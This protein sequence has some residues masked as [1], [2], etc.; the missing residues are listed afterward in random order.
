MSTM[1]Q[2]AP[3]FDAD[4]DT[5]T[6][7]VHNHM[8]AYVHFG[9]QVIKITYLPNDEACVKIPMSNATGR[10]VTIS[11]EKAHHFI[12]CAEEM[13][14]PPPEQTGPFPMPKLKM[15]EPAPPQTPIAISTTIPPGWGGGS[16]FEK[17]RLARLALLEERE[18]EEF[19]AKSA[20]VM[21]QIMANATKNFKVLM[22][23]QDSNT[24]GQYASTTIDFSEAT[25]FSWV[26]G[27]FYEVQFKNGAC[28]FATPKYFEYYPSGHIPDRP[29]TA[30]SGKWLEPRDFSRVALLL[31]PSDL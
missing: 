20:E 12:E 18:N 17:K 27:N 7:V 15:P 3:G 6:A 31:E 16:V 4:M 2:L 9:D 28:L 10:F 5:V 11:R 24:S 8:G 25:S 19:R 1:Y 13:V 22:K 29:Y 26:C 14:M 23:I 30:L 21:K